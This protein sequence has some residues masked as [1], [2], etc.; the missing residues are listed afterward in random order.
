MHTSF[1]VSFAIGATLGLILTTLFELWL[2]KDELD[3]ETL[4][5]DSE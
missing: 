5:T 2:V 4:L 3:W 1:L